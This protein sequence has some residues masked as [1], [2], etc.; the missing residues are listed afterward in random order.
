[1]RVIAGT[2][3]RTLLVTPKGEDTRPT[4]DRIKETLFNIIRDDIVDVSFLDLFAGSGGIGIE[5]LSRGASDA[6][7]V[8]RS[9]VAYKCIRENVAKTHFDDRSEILKMD[10]KSALRQLGTA[11]RKFGMIFADPPYEAGYEKSI[12]EEIDRNC[13]M[14]DEA[15]VIIEAGLDTSF[16]FAERFGYVI[17]RVKEYKTNKH[18]FLCMKD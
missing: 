11:G 10:Y 8:E 16:E 4:T 2:A 13:L 15:T 9:G 1:M 17:R 12:L 14:T 5:A 6:V 3:R 18:V 7:F